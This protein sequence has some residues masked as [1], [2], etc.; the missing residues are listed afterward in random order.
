MSYSEIEL[1]KTLSSSLLLTMS[2]YAR[3]SVLD[4]A[5]VGAF[6][7]CDPRVPHPGVSRCPCSAVAADRAELVGR[8]SSVAGCTTPPGRQNCPRRRGVDLLFSAGRGCRPGTRS[9]KCFAEAGAEPRS[10]DVLRSDAASTTCRP[11]ALLSRPLF[12]R[13]H[14]C[15]RTPATT[16]RG[17]AG[18]RKRLSTRASFVLASAGTPGAPIPVGSPSWPK[19]T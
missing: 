19:V 12:V 8:V 9:L 4:D 18:L 10:S 16:V 2:L 13:A 7:R 15:T 17:A 11:E 6:F 5:F 14:R 3:E 1:A